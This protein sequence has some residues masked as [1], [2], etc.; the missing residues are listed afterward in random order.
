MSVVW[1]HYFSAFGFSPSLDKIMTNSPLHIIWDGF[2]AVSIF[3]VLSGFVL[4]YKYFAPPSDSSLRQLSLRTF[5]IARLAR[6]YLPFLG[7]LCLSAL[8]QRALP[9]VLV[10]HPLSTSWLQP[11]W[12]NLETVRSFFDQALL[13]KYAPDTTL[14]LIPQD[15]S[16]T[17][18]FNISLIFPF[19]VLVAC[20]SSFWILALT[21]ISIPILKLPM[22]L[23]HFMLGI[24]MAKHLPALRQKVGALKKLTQICLFLLGLFFYTYRYSVYPY[25]PNLLAENRIWYVT[26]LASALVILVA[27][28][29]RTIQR[30]LRHPWLV[31]LG[32]ISYSVY[33]IHFAIFLSFCTRFM[34]FAQTAGITDDNTLRLLGLAFLTLSTLVFSTFSY[35]FLEVPCI[36]LGR[37]L[38]GVSFTLADSIWRRLS[39]TAPD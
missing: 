12:A 37:R 35:Y 25:F 8:L 30:L 23:F 11:F 19:L 34:A 2:A 16:L 3:F 6:I 26:G 1:S 24:L 18:E 5:Y 22:Y 10:S 17:I 27:L 28:T 15:W 31:F 29:S 21:L 4:A 13:Y 33:L 7:V 38:S 9:P 39:A 32:K 20:R 36:Q 14:R